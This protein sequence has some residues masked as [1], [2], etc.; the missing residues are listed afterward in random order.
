METSDIIEG[1]SKELF[2]ETLLQ[3][4]INEG[5][6]DI[7]YAQEKVDDFTMKFKCSKVVEYT[8]SE[9]CFRDI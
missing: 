4:A 7:V 2:Q 6:I 9:D 3:Y 5:I 1:L 8:K